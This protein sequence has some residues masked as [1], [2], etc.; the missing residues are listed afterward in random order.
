MIAIPQPR[1]AVTEHHVIHRLG[2]EGQR[3]RAGEFPPEGTQSVQSGPRT[4]AVA[5]DWPTDQ[6]LPDERPFEPLGDLCGV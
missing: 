1:P 5:L 2:P 6:R 4:K 3:L